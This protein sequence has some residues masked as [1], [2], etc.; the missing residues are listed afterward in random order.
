M[1][2]KASC[3]GASFLPFSPHGFIT[4][5]QSSLFEAKNKDILEDLGDL[6]HGT[7]NAQQSDE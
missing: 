4:Q 2:R 1:I 6:G 7:D 5:V 3:G